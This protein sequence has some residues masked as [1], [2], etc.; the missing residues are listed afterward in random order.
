MTNYEVTGHYLEFVGPNSHNAGGSSEKFY[1]VFIIENVLVIRY[2]RLGARPGQFSVTPCGSHEAAEDRGRKQLYAKRDKGYEEQTRVVF[3]IDQATYDATLAGR[4][5]PI[6]NDFDDAKESGAFSAEKAGVVQN[7]NDFA[8]RATDLMQRA[9][10][11]QSHEVA[12]LISEFHDLKST[13]VEIDTRVK[14]VEVAL[15]FTEQAVS[16]SFVSQR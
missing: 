4:L 9:N 12:G 11:A 8:D 6:I 14:Q 16:Q 10:V 5:D 13:W 1:Q 2:G 7:L 3:T 15:M